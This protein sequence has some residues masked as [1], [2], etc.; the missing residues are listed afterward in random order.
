[1]LGVGETQVTHRGRER[2]REIRSARIMIFSAT[3]F[4]RLCTLIEITPGGYICTM[5]ARR[6]TL[7]PTIKQK[8]RYE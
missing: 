7:H 5:F 8:W 2:E 4:S 1:M 3:M 6:L